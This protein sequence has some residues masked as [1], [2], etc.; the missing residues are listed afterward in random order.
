MLVF[1][2]H[3]LTGTLTSDF[4]SSFCTPSFTILLH[5]FTDQVL[6]LILDH[7]CVYVSRKEGLP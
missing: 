2:L 5:V 6:I 3:L 1:L 4:T 7:T